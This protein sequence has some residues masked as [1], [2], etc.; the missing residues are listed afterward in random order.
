[1]TVAHFYNGGSQ[2]KVSYKLRAITSVKL[3][4]NLSSGRLKCV[5]PSHFYTF[6]PKTEPLNRSQLSGLGNEQ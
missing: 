5:T 1:M 4:S 2:L 6:H 3:S